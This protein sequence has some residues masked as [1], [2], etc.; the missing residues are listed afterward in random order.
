MRVRL[1]RTGICALAVVAGGAVAQP[2]AYLP[3]GDVV[4]VWYGRSGGYQY[5]AGG[6]NGGRYRP[7]AYSAADV[8]VTAPAW[9]AP[10][11]YCACVMR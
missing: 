11:R 6:Y 4:P 3:P 2:L 10:V 5:P 9:P 1:L 7:G 8:Y